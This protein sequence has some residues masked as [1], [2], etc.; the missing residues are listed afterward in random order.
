[1]DLFSVSLGIRGE[2]LVMLYKVPSVNVYVIPAKLKV[3][4]AVEAN[5]Y[6]LIFW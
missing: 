4:E 3:R 5:K 1:M 2:V 6:F